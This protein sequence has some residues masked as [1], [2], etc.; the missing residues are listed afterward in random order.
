MISIPL[1]S[2]LFVYI[3]FLAVFVVFMC[4]HLYH[5]ISTASFTLISFFVVFSVFAAAA[6]ILYTTYQLVGGGDVNWQAPLV[7]FNPDWFG[8]VFGS[9][10][11]F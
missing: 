10:N 4:I 8:S 11:S 6:I 1:Y 7:L 5:I 2:I 9:E 3:L